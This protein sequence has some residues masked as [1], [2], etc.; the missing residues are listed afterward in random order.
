M[1]DIS[2]GEP[3]PERPRVA[4]TDPDAPWRIELQTL[5]D[6]NRRGL[7]DPTTADVAAEMTA[8]TM[9][10]FA[11]IIADEPDAEQL[12]QRGTYRLLFDSLRLDQFDPSKIDQAMPSP[13]TTAKIFEDLL[14]QLDGDDPMVLARE[15]SLLA[16]SMSAMRRQGYATDEDLAAMTPSGAMQH[17]YALVKQHGSLT[18]RLGPPVPSA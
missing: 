4:E 15:W 3:T 1:N 18:G 5:L 6:Y 16:P 12:L 9:A 8:G 10:S 17:L 14:G 11:D 7:D 2:K 13:E